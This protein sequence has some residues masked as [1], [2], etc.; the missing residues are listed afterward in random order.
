M[1]SPSCPRLVPE[2]PFPPYSYVTGHFPHPL[3]DPQGHSFG[4]KPRPVA[5]LEPDQ[6]ASSQ[7]YLAAIDLFNHGYYWE[8]HE[9]WEGL[10]HAAGRS[11]LLADFLKGLIKLAAAGVKA[12][13]GRTDG[14]KRHAQRAGELFAAT[15]D[16]SNESRR[17][18]GLDLDELVTAAS[19]LVHAPPVTRR[20]GPSGRTTSAEVPPVEIVFDFLLMPDLCGTP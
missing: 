12:R 1:N 3:R 5:T 16:R 11:G 18:L 20:A 4:H 10:W 9:A 14:V 7:D 8:A 15:R 6:W 13:E 19:G 2:R 17:F